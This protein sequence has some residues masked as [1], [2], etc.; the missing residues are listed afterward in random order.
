MTLPRLILVGGFLGAGKTTL[1]LA[2]ARRLAARGMRVGLVTNDQGAGL[3]DTALVNVHA[4][5]V[6]EVSGGCFCCRFPDLLQALQ[7]LQT[8]AAPEVILAEPVGSCTDLT[9]TVLRPLARDYGQ[10]YT[11]APLTIVVGADRNLA[12]FSGDVAYLH[13]RQTA[14]AELLLLNKSDLL[15]P[16]MQDAAIHQLAADYP[17]AQVFPMSARAATGLQPWLEMVMTRTSDHPINL[18]LDY[19]RYTEAEAE[20]GWCNVRG[21]LEATIPVHLAEWTEALLTGLAHDFQG[22]ALAVAHLKLH[23]TSGRHNAKASLTA[24]QGPISW[25][26]YPDDARVP[27]LQ[28]VFN[29]RVAADPQQLEQLVRR[30][31]ARQA[32]L[33]AAQ[34]QITHL[35]CFRPAPPKPTYRIPLQPHG[36]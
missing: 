3:V 8:A 32:E 2:A 11:L 12:E 19:Q 35:E 16:P 13:E 1:L 17:A 10:Q 28:F 30:Q 21:S 26:V 20:M 9:A 24:S 34:C 25:D 29:A 15:S 23:L 18:S 6:T 27:G 36:V 7:R 14:E 31:L 22:D 5:P 33:R 4:I